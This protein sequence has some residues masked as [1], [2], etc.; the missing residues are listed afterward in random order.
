MLK[1]LLL[2]TLYITLIRDQIIGSLKLSCSDE[3]FHLFEISKTLMESRISREFLNHTKYCHLWQYELSYI[4]FPSNKL[5]TIAT[6]C[7][8]SNNCTIERS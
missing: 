2:N 6:L 8:P 4:L 7:S 5:S 3:I 1:N